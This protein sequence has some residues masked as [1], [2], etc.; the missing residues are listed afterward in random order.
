MQNA[1]LIL[2]LILN[3]FIRLLYDEIR[4]YIL[5][6]G[7]YWGKCQTISILVYDK[8]DKSFFEKT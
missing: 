8:D 6:V 5:V 3:Q 1:V 7:I 4:Q 2:L